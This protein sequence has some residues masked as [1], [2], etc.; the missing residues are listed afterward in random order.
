MRRGLD[1]VQRSRY[2]HPGEFCTLPGEFSLQALLRI[3][4]AQG[5]LLKGVRSALLTATGG[6]CRYTE[7][8]GSAFMATND[9]I[10]HTAC[11]G[12]ESPVQNSG[13]IPFDVESKDSHTCGARVARYQAQERRDEK[14]DI[15]G[16]LSVYAGRSFLIPGGHRVIDLTWNRCSKRFDLSPALDVKIVVVDNT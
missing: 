3:E 15:S 9:V 11:A 8:W 6:R 13:G 14:L 10:N 12:E 7:V 1:A 2:G 4:T 5:V 16:R